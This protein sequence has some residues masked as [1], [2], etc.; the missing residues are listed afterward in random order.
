VFEPIRAAAGTNS[1]RIKSVSSVPC[2]LLPVHQKRSYTLI[3][4]RTEGSGSTR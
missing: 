1:G 3:S 2:P 4:H